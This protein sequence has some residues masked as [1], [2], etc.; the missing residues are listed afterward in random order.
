MSPPP[1]RHSPHA[2][3]RVSSDGMGRAAAAGTGLLANVVAGVGT[4]IG[5]PR[6]TAAEADEHLFGGRRNM[7]DG[8]GDSA[9]SGNSRNVENTGVPR[10]IDIEERTGDVGGGHKDGV[11]ERVPQARDSDSTGQEYP[12]SF[13]GGGRQLGREAV[14]P[15]LIAA[16]TVA[17]GSD[18]NSTFPG[19]AWSERMENNT[20]T[21]RGMGV[22]SGGDG[23]SRPMSVHG[24]TSSASEQDKNILRTLDDLDRASGGGGGGPPSGSGG[25]GEGGSMFSA[26]GVAASATGS[27]GGAVLRGLWGGLQAGVASAAAVAREGGDESCDEPA[28]RLYRRED[29]DR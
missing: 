27:A 3:A 13:R 16:S 26:L 12:G 19:H 20:G 5:A 17:G 7:M 4:A 22:S 11:D 8:L 29:D 28:V 23:R 2:Q 6:A 15:S 9:G 25:V 14:E 1:A 24:T 21:Q 18:P 10:K